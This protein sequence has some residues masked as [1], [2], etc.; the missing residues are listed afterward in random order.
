MNQY[1][2]EASVWTH[3]NKQRKIV[4]LKLEA[5]NIALALNMFVEHY[6]KILDA[7]IFVEYKEIGKFVFPQEE[8]E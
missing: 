5:T 1:Y 3:F 8:T 6:S 2:I 7:E 4:A